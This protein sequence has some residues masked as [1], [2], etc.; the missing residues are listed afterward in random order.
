MI[1]IQC[2]CGKRLKVADEAAG[3]KG[4]CPACGNVFAIRARGAAETAAPAARAASGSAP[5]QRSPAA[6]TPAASTAA[7]SAG[8][9]PAAQDDFFS[10]LPPIVRPTPAPG[11]PGA[12][13]YEALMPQGF[14]H[15][16][17][18]KDNPY[19]PPAV[20]TPGR[21]PAP[22]AGG[23]CP[24]CGHTEYKKVG[25]TFWGGIIGPMIL[26]HVRCTGCRTTYNS[27]TGKSNN[28]AIA[29]Y[30]G[31]SLALGAA[32]G[33]AGVIASLAN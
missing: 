25:W 19:A 11:T 4:K 29:I 5:A 13:G 16:P 1:E 18:P 24:H 8:P 22:S 32:L 6:S 28:T 21:G 3:K 15:V 23:R 33:I 20:P 10:D 17:V 2:K 26:S 27:K 14:D 7:R 12:P 9:S 30:L 31:V